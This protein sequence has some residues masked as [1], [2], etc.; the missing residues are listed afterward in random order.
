MLRQGFL[1][2]GDRVASTGLS[3]G[4]FRSLAA[5]AAMFS[6]FA[7][8]ESRAADPFDMQWRELA[9]G[10]WVGER[11]V[12]YRS[13]VMTNTTVVIGKTGVLVFDAA[14]LAVQGERLVAKLAELT[15]RPITHIAISHW[16][17]D[18]SMG[19]YAVLE[20]F[21][22]AE[23]I[24][25][26]F[27]ARYIASPNGDRVEP[28]DLKAEAEYK[29]RVEKALETGVRSDGT[30][31]TP[32]MRAFYSGLLADFDIVNREIERREVTRPT[33]T[34][35]DRLVLDLGGRTAELRHI[36]PGNTKGDMFL[37]LP[38]EKILATGDIVVR[39]TPYGFFSYPRSWAG[40]LR[41]LKTLGATQIV[42]GHGEIMNDTAYLDL[43]AETMDLVATQVDAAVKAGKTLDETR[44]AMDWS[45]VG[46]RFTGGDDG[47]LPVLFDIW[48]KTPI[49]EAQYN[50]S[51]G[52]DNESLEASEP[53][54][55]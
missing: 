22:A 26:E 18:H 41:E 27:T 9:S 38:A 43:L 31:V 49:V 23:V 39:P 42:P 52:K 54:A 48:F 2:E 8:A 36:A 12:S 33:R 45:T 7:A 25:H 51:S 11:P 3:L 30:P 50:L 10:V 21:P 47:M 37:W 55:T 46:S 28:R 20:K 32:G 29:A 1:S 53:P 34:M 17:G 6:L 15:D 19:D 35:T 4:R 40:V 44:A 24:S 13:P 14:G 5:A 16:H